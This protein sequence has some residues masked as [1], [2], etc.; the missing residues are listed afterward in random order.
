MRLN[1]V[2]FFFLIYAV[3]A[4]PVQSDKDPNPGNTIAQK[5]PKFTL[6]PVTMPGGPTILVPSTPS[7]GAFNDLGE[8]IT[9]KLKK[10]VTG[11]TTGFA[12]SYAK[13][14]SGSPFTD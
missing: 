7:E 2:S 9:P 3:S 14:S 10:F 6:M 1:L 13:K 5:K 11:A 4:I 8:A 12:E